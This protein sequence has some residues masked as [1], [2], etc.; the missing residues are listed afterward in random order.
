M[1]EHPPDVVASLKE[2]YCAGAT[3]RAFW[4]PYVASTH[5]DLAQKSSTTFIMSTL[6]PV[7]PPGV[8]AR[9][10]DLPA[11]LEK[12]TGRPWPPQGEGKGK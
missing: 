1:V 7:L 4:L 8:G 11:L 9:H 12:L 5:G 2:A 10:R 3:S 6:G